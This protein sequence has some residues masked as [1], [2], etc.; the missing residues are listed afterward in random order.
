MFSASFQHGKS[1]TCSQRVE[2]SVPLH[3]CFT[4][5]L[6]YM[7]CRCVFHYMCRRCV[8]QTHAA[9]SRAVDET[10]VTD[11]LSLD[12]SYWIQRVGEVSQ[13]HSVTVAITVHSGPVLTYLHYGH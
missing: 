8:F 9:L 4:R 13:L 6:H 7:C 12:K 5:V 2:M 11:P 3:V 1:Y 10:G